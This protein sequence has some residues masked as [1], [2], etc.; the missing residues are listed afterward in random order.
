[1]ASEDLVQIILVQ[2]LDEKGFQ[3][4]N[5]YCK[6]SIKYLSYFLS[7]PDERRIDPNKYS[8]FLT[9][10]KCFNLIEAFSR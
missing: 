7:P 5:N 6:V 8:D 3:M 1:M 10:T 2:G 4:K 9:R